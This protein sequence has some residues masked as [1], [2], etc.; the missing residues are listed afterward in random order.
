MNKMLYNLQ[1]HSIIQ[2]YYPIYEG[3]FT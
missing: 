2:I 3:H 1:L